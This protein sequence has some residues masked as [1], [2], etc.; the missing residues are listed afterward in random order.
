MRATSLLDG[1]VADN[2]TKIISQWKNTINSMPMAQ[3]SIIAIV[4][5]VIMIILL[6]YQPLIFAIILILLFGA[7]FLS[8]KVNVMQSDWKFEEEQKAKG[9][10]KFV[11]KLNKVHWGSEEAVKRWRDEE[12]QSTPEKKEQ[13]TYERVVELEEEVERLKAAVKKLEEKEDKPA[14]PN[15]P[16]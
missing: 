10:Y 13:V 11:D 8:Q 14:Q 6:V 7:Y 15:P 4:A 16:M 2:I 1:R 9:L 3:K 12:R 5:L